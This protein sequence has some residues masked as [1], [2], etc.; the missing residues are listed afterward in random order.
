MPVS[1]SY[2]PLEWEP[3]PS[4]G[5]VPEAPYTSRPEGL[6]IQSFLPSAPSF[7]EHVTRSYLVQ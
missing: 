4:Y 5:K 3:G 7:Q 1:A 6:S 2:S